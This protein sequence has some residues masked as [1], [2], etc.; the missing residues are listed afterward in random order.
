[1]LHEI[2]PDFQ[3]LHIIDSL[4]I[5]SLTM[6][7]PSTQPVDTSGPNPNGEEFDNLYLDMNGIVHPCTHP[8]GKVCQIGKQCI[9]SPLT[10]T[11]TL[12][13]CAQNRGSYDARG[14]PVHRPSG[15]D[16]QTSQA[17]RYGHRW[18][19]SSSQNESAAQSSFPF[20]SRSQAE[21]AGTS[22][23]YCRMGM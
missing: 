6:F 16:G 1:M 23:C 14:V 21:R 22:N 7:V 19:S 10:D 4:V 13:A 8:E 5:R 15:F 17:P 3:R 2:S 11:L 9:R 20:G 12:P 18:R